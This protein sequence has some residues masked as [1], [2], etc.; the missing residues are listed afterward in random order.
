MYTRADETVTKNK[1]LP[2]NI[3]GIH[4]EDEEQDEKWHDDAH[5][6]QGVV[7]RG[8]KPNTET[9]KTENKLYFLITFY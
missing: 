9:N 1:E 6:D 4:M 8:A 2:E 3:R 5:K 7:L